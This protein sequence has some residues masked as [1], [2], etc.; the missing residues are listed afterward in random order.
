MAQQA[1][2]RNW[3][4]TIN[5]P[6]NDDI[7]RTFTDVKYVIWQREKGAEG[8][9][10][11][12]GYVAFSKQLRLAGVK[13]LDNTAHWEARKGTEQQCIDYCSKV[14]T[15][16]LGPWELGERSRPGERN[17]LAPLERIRQQIIGGASLKQIADSDFKNFLRYGR[18]IA[19]YARLTARPRSE[20]PKVY[21]LWGPTGTGKSTYARELAGQNSYAKPPG[22][23]WFTGYDGTSNVIIDEFYGWLPHYFLL[24]L[25]DKYPLQVQIHHGMVNFDAKVIVLTSNQPPQNWYH[26]HD[27]APLRR[28]FHQVI[29]M[30]TLGGP[31]YVH[32]PDGTRVLLIEDN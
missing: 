26:N 3:V 28:R 19:D 31:K 27:Y 6:L 24:T 25:L 9:E 15:R 12:Q 23:V 10:H 22:T 13:K 30:P 2:A 16:L 7:P 1:K 29:E 17:D 20:M 18:G 5:N 8:T 14:D 21:V 11:L 4:F 32:E